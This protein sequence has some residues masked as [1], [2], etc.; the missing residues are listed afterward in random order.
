MCV[1]ARSN[2]LVMVHFDGEAEWQWDIIILAL[3]RGNFRV[4][5]PTLTGG[6]FF[7]FYTKFSASPLEKIM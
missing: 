2:A 6:L 3:D 7:C 4:Y 1:Q 5:D